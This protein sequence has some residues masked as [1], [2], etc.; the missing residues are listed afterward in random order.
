MRDAT[1][2]RLSTL[3]TL[4]YRLTR[5]RLGRRLV[6]NDMLLLTTTGRRS[7]HRHTI[8]LLYLRDGDSFIV[9]ASWG[10]RDYPPHWYLNVTADPAVSIQIDGSV[11]KAVARELDEPERS[12]WWQHAVTAYEGYGTYQSRT[13]RVI[14]ILRLTPRDQGR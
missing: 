12:E 6:D 11:W 14:P 9:I 7:G 2:R 1:A 3:H 5:G 4:A 8:P 13:D 10:G